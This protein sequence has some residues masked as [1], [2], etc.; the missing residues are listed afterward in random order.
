[1]DRDFVLLMDI[2]SSARMIQAYV[3]D[4]VLDQFLKDTQLQDS[5]IRRFE[6]I[7]EAAGR[8]SSQFQEKYEEIPWSEMRGMRNRM[9]HRYDDID[10][11]IVWN[12]A[13]EDIPHLLAIIE[14]LASPEGE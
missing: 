1:M 14:P 9:I 3:K 4:I 8:I 6:I 12:T 7:G 2:L 11:N 5:V 10:M 13:Q